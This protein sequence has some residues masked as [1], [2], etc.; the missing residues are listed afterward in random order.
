[1]AIVIAPTARR[2]IRYGL[3]RT[4]LPVRSRVEVGL[5]RAYE[6]YERARSRGSDTA[7]LNAGELPLP[8]AKLRVLVCGSADPEYFLD[9]G[10]RHAALFREMVD[11][12]GI[13][14]EEWTAILDFGVGCGRVARWWADVQGP[15]MYGCDPNPLLA[16][17]TRAHMPFVNAA[18]SEQDPP[19]P[20][21]DDSFDFV[22]ALSIF[23]HLG[24]R[25]ALPWM[26]E[27]RRII[28]P[29]GLL[30]LTVAGE[31]YRERLEP[32]DAGRYDRGEEVVQFDSARGT[33]L[34]IA[35]HSPAYMSGRMLDGFELVDTLP[36]SESG[37]ALM[38]QDCY[39]AR[40]P[41]R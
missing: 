21:A 28:K 36:A 7:L 25:H 3:L 17:W 40:V 41:V 16:N 33:N 9:A 31:A 18:V 22:Y 10:R 5:L 6:A 30:L 34:C 19:L 35:Y 12:N 23:T 15:A 39:L 32:G 14:P 27:L 24:E 13:D 11:R 29:G 37:D 4:P 1:V 38:P 20:Y 8:P 2:T 26:T